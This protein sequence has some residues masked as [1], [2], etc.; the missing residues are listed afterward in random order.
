MLILELKTVQANPFK[1]LIEALKEFLT[2][3]N[4]EFT[5]SVPNHEGGLSIIALNNSS[6][7]L[8]HLKLDAKNFDEFSCKHEQINIGVNMTYLFKLI[9]TINNT[10]ILTLF[11][12]D[13]DINKL[14]IKIE[15]SDKNYISTYKLNL[16][17]LDKTIYSIP[18][19]D[20]TTIITMSSHEFHKICKDL[21]II[22]DTVEIKSYQK[23]LIFTATGDIASNEVICGETIN[24][25]T[26]VSKDDDEIIQ[27]I[28]DLKNLILFTKC[29][30]LCT[31]VELY[32]KN[33]YPIVIKYDV[34]QLGSVHLC[35]SSITTN[36]NE[37]NESDTGSES[38]SESD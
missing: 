36:I 21:S 26:I 24:G 2:D 1:I 37:F 10:D 29:T 6:S 38:D 30:N 20:F 15:N 32:M 31:N 34:A 14:G 17:D 27:G 5:K 28:Y 23:K 22:S 8:V 13:S 9:K 11:L 19:T 33:D 25:L 16:M 12:E 4:I 35:L 7:I 18:P 3:V